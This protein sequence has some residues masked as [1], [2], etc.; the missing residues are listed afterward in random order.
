[1]KYWHSDSATLLDHSGDKN[2]HVVLEVKGN[3][4][5]WLGYGLKG[6]YTN[7][8]NYNYARYAFDGTGAE[9]GVTNKV[10]GTD[11]H[12]NIY[13]FEGANYCWVVNTRTL[14][15]KIRVTAWMHQGPVPV[16]ILRQKHICLY[17]ASL[18]KPNP[19]IRVREGF[20]RFQA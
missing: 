7:M 4:L 17:R 8:E 15:G 20:R 18:R 11:G 16:P 3:P 5:Q 13:P 19:A 12:V 14:T 9:N 10:L 1:M 2:G 6:H